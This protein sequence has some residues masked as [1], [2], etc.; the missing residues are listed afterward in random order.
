M[1]D[2]SRR[3]TLPEIMDDFSLQHQEID[4]V[5]KELEVINKLLGGFG[6]FY[7][8]FKKIKLTNG[9]LICDWGCGGG[10]SLLALRNH[11]KKKNLDLEY[12]GLD[13]TKTA[14]EF[15]KHHHLNYQEITFKEVDV[16]KETFE[17]NQYNVVISSLFTHHFEDEDWIKL[18]QRMV[19]SAKKA[20]IINDLHRHP[21]AY[22]SIALLTQIFSKSY[23]VKHDSKVS[24]LR[25][26]KRQE[27]RNLL[28]LAGVKNYN[29]KWMWAFRWQIIIYK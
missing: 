21:L 29:I 28:A 26:F 10:D 6:V 24:V 17:E 3:S 14:V 2:F 1:P 5:L 20:V 4:P 13:A 25:S 18:V 16:L 12:L 27:L 15:A 9:D 22:Y 23:M 8:A 11:F 19:F 7:N